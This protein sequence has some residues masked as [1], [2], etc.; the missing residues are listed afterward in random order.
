MERD[1]CWKLD[2]LEPQGLG[3]L[4]GLS[5]AETAER[6]TRDIEVSG[7][8]PDERMS[9]N[10]PEL[11]KSSSFLRGYKK[12]NRIWKK[13]KGEVKGVCRVLRPRRCQD[14][15]SGIDKADSH[16]PSRVLDGSTAIFKGL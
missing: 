8:E 7:N 15:R 12:K 4:E 2:A 1:I 3:T 16:F 11:V 14:P 9:R 6:H 13:N 10:K 5:K